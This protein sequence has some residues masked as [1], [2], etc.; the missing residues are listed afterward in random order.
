MK[1]NRQNG[2]GTA[3]I[4][5]ASSGIGAIYADRLAK[6][7]YD[8]ILVARDRN[9]LDILATRLAEE[10][11]V[12]TESL[13]ADL[14][15]K[16]DLVRVEE[17]LRN[18]K[19]IALLLNNA[20]MSVEGSLVG[21]DLDHLETMIQLNVVATTRLA[22]AVAP[23]FVARGRGTIINIASVVALAPELFNGAYSGT[24]AYLLNLSQALHQEI[25]AKG[26]RVQAVLPGATRTAIW[27]KSG[28]DVSK[29]P[30]GILMEVDEMVDAALAG[31]DLEEI[32]TIPSL[33]NIAEWEAFNAARLA[34][35]PNLS[36]DHSADR[37]KTALLK[38]GDRI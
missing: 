4:T 33:P 10:T 36:R 17:R 21:G 30:A 24:K 2:K 27:E 1:T 6:R 29:L 16:S 26:V 9:K 28:T 20:G 18:D 15:S 12:K 31:L 34:L 32:V 11:G 7:G 37:Y 5:G 19:Q 35:G 23:A 13:Q 8:L 22:G 3:L 14:T 38:P 25:G